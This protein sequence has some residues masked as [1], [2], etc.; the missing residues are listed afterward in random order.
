MKEGPNIA[1]IGALVGDPTRANI[2]T[3][4][5]GGAALTATELAVECGVTQQTV[6]A[7]LA[8]L[9]AGGLLRQR[10]Q[11][12]HRYFQLSGEDVG[13]LLE[14][15]M[16]LAASRGHMRVR[17]GPKDPALRKARVCYNHLAGDYG[18]RMY[19]SLLAEGALAEDGDE[20]RLTPVGE[21]FATEFGVDLDGLKRLRRPLCRACLDWSARESHLAGALGSALLERMLAV[22]WARKHANSRV[23]TFMPAGERAF[24]HIFGEV[25]TA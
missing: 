10:K 18:V 23:V 8:K 9:E 1:M 22:G 4:L 12:R 2:L 25:E 19:K 16:G 14:G 13:D 7:H 20:L 6:S 17:P 15:M 5:M 21:N 24:H 11:G 3:A